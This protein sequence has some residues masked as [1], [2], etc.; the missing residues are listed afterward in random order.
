MVPEPSVPIVAGKLF[1]GY[2]PLLHECG[3]VLHRMDRM[4]RVVT[5]RKYVSMKFTPP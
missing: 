4:G 1:T 2:S 3:S 5:Y